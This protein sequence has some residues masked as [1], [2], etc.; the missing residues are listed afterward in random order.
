MTKKKCPPG[1][2]AGRKQSDRPDQTAARADVP[3]RNVATPD[4]HPQE[5]TWQTIGGPGSGKQ[6][7]DAVEF[8]AMVDAAGGDVAAAVQRWL[9]DTGR[10]EPGTPITGLEIRAWKQNQ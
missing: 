6:G 10:I 2:P 9:V 5:A 7:F 1:C 8:K 4:H 3:G